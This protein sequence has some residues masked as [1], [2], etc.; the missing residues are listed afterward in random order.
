[1]AVW[2]DVPTLPGT[3][4][5]AAFLRELEQFLFGRYD[6][7]SEGGHA[8]A[9]V[10]W[11]KGWAYTETEA[12]QDADVIGTAVPASFGDGGWGRAAGVLDRLDPHRVSA[13][14]SCGGCWAETPP[15]GCGRGP[16]GRA[17]GPA[18]A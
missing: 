5:A 4:Y 7:R 1:M 11:S 16:R 13:T 10:E 9:R 3:P 14:R 15:T 8:L 12:W 17:W 6:G 2:L 18:S